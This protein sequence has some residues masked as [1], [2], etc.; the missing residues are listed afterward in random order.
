[1]VAARVA[2]ATGKKGVVGLASDHA[3]PAGRTVRDG[4][5]SR[6]QGV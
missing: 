2:A 6:G 5:L 3:T 1:V 4:S